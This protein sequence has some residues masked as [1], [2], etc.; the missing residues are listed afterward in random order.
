MFLCRST[1]QQK[2]RTNSVNYQSWRQH[3]NGV[4]RTYTGCIERVNGV[5]VELV[6][7]GD[8]TLGTDR[9][10]ETWTTLILMRNQPP[11][12][13]N[14]VPILRRVPGVQIRLCEV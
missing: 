14:W 5:G 1:E 8:E 10:V 12:I 11:P 7:K 3:D 2:S 6:D 9:S 13:H 4:L